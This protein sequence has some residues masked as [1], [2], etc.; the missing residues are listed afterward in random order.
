MSGISFACSNCGGK[1]RV[2]NAYAGKSGTCKHC[3]AKILA[4]RQ[5]DPVKQKRSAKPQPPPIPEPKERAIERASPPP[6]P[7]TPGP[8]RQQPDSSSRKPRKDELSETALL[9]II[10]YFIIVFIVYIG[11]LIS[12]FS[13]YPQTGGTL[14]PTWFFVVFF[15][16]PSTAILV[17]HYRKKA[18]ITNAERAAK[19]RKLLKDMLNEND[20]QRIKMQAERCGNS[21]RL[22][23]R[24][25][26]LLSLLEQHPDSTYLRQET[27]RIGRVLK[28][29][30]PSA[31]M[32]ILNDISAASSNSVKRESTPA[33]S[34]DLP[35]EISKLSNLMSESILTPDEFSLAKAKLLGSHPDKAA[36]MAKSLRGIY[37]LMQE[38]VL[39]KG[40]FNLKKWEIL[41]KRD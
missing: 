34:L 32:A 38:G 3:G 33:P 15:I 16:A 36:P 20:T 41:S 24:Y 26:I 21:L 1:L 6:I 11:I 30:D 25:R 4:P 29:D 12:E 37:E 9:R 39:S 5:N 19:Y 18:S 35:G 14:N 22:P 31:E 28:R 7:A 40:E 17:I 10:A 13:D 8:S 2:S 23:H 27:L